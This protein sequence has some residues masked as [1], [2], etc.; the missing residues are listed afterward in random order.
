MPVTRIT[1]RLIGTSML[2]RALRSAAA[3]EAKNG[4]PA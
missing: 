2:L 4:M 3:A 1:P